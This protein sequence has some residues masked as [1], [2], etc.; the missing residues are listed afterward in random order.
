MDGLSG[1]G[2]LSAGVGAGCGD[3]CHG[4]HQAMEPATMA[5]ATNAT[6]AADDFSRGLGRA[7]P[8]PNFSSYRIKIG[9]L[10]ALFNIH[11]IHHFE[12]FED[13][14]SSHISF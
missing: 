5:N 2:V 11:Q 13:F 8:M 14:L 12:D 1:S 4:S 9:Y 3:D 10:G 6:T 7:S